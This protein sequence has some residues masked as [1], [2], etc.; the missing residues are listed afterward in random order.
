MIYY[1]T[2][3]LHLIVHEQNFLQISNKGYISFDRKHRTGPTV[4]PSVRESDDTNAEDI[5]APFL[6]FTKGC[7]DSTAYFSH[8]R[9]MDKRIF[10]KEII[11]RA[12]D[13]IND[14]ESGNGNFEPSDVVIVTWNGTLPDFCDFVPS[15]TCS[16]AEVQQRLL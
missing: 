5:V 4:F 14:F 13:D 1:E 7:Y 15:C 12:K 11:Q 10:I 8:F 16:A 3:Q 6:A 2:T 9:S